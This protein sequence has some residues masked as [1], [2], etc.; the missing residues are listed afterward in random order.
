MQVK[1]NCSSYLSLQCIQ[2][3]IFSFS[4]M[5]GLLHWK[6]ELPKKLFL[7][8]QLSKTEFSRDSQTMAERGWRRFMGRHCRDKAGTEV[9][10]PIICHMM[11]MTLRVP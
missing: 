8:G 3:C 10:M 6:P 7:H 1:S 2:I 11:A 9:S 4:G 5:L